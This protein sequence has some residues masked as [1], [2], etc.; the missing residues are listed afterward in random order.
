M[1][2][3]GHG[4]PFLGQPFGYAAGVARGGALAAWESLTRHLLADQL[5]D[6]V[7]LVELP[8]REALADAVEKP[9]YAQ[10]GWA[11]P[12]AYPLADAVLELLR[13]EP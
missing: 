1:D 11:W 12:G 10:G 4:G 9:Y 3:G 6:P 8:S 5:V 2:L 13:G 7:P